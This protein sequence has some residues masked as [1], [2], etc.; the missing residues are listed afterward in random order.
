[1]ASPDSLGASTRAFIDHMAILPVPAAESGPF[2]M[3][4]A[5]PNCVA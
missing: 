5:Q 4:G 3:L 1:M 2:E